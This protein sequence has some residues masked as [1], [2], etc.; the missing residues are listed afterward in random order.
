MFK[1]G[2]TIIRQKLF[3]IA[4]QKFCVER[5]KSLTSLLEKISKIHSFNKTLFILR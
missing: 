2:K 3:A 1:Q 5:A 4:I